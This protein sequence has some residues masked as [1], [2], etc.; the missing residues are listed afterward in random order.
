MKCKGFHCW[1][2]SMVSF[3]LLIAVSS[4]LAGTAMA[5]D[6]TTSTV[7][8]DGGTLKFE[9][10]PGT[11]NFDPIPLTGLEQ[12][13]STNL[14]DFSVVDAR[15]TGEGWSVQVSATNLMNGVDKEMPDGS[16]SLSKPIEMTQGY[17]G[18]PNSL[19]VIK[20]FTL[21]PI[22]GAGVNSIITATT[23]NGLGKWTINW[24]APNNQALKLRIDP[25][26]VKTG[27]Y[28]STI[29]WS[30]VAPVDL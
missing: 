27:T 9:D 6:V 15:G 2:L 14:S 24:G 20:D 22:D 23:G 28:Q 29:T 5:A 16:L 26:V 1:E 4:S 19:P 10:V 30:L 18:T 13:V 21:L 3:V 25:G 12:N 7:T 17:T 11:A 8:I